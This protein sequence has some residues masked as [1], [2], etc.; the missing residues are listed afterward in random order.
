MNNLNM[1]V[2]SP[3]EKDAFTVYNY[4]NISIFQWEIILVNK[5]KKMENRKRI[6]REMKNKIKHWI[7]M[8]K[9]MKLLIRVLIWEKLKNP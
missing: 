4:Q 2:I 7:R 9:V 1:F 8:I 3:K 5:I 6:R